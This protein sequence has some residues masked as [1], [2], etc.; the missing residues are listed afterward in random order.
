MLLIYTGE[1]RKKIF[2]VCI[3]SPWTCPL[4]LLCRME[5]GVGGKGKTTTCTSWTNPHLSDDL[6]KARFT[7]QGKQ[8]LW[9]HCWTETLR[10]LEQWRTYYVPTKW[11][12][13]TLLRAA[14]ICR[15]S[16]LIN[17]PKV[18]ENRSITSVTSNEY[19]Y[20]Y[21][22]LSRKVREEKSLMIFSDPF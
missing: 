2:K 4:R 13:T 21:W 20:C 7:G 15:L 10:V 8:W 18:V 17:S 14:S 16:F 5:K 11:K 22:N 19:S 3:Y 6:G 1:G 9:R 12:I